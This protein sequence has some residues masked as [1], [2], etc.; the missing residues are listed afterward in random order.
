MEELYLLYTDDFVHC[1]FCF[2]LIFAH[3]RIILVSYIIFRD[4]D[5]DKFY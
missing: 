3:E 4:K 2:R 1:V 5:V